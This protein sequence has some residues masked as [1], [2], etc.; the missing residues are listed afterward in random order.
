MGL[1]T[2]SK[3]RRHAI[4]LGFRSGLE[5]TISN[6]IKDAGLAVSYEEDK[7]NYVWPERSSVYTPDFKLP[8]VGGFFLV[9]TKG[10]F[11]VDDRQKHLLIKQQHPHIDIRFVFSN[12][13]QR[14]YK[15]SPTRYCD[16]CDKHG[17]LYAHKRIPDE[18][19]QEGANDNEPK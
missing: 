1:R 13:N 19:L 7:I 9:E 2:I 8:K 14:I 5:E 10:R 11:S 12:Q 4:A 16:W 17:F 6:Q 3:R 15:N 18:W